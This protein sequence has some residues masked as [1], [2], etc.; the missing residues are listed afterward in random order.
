MKR[1]L[2]LIAVACW[3]LSSSVLFAD[4]FYKGQVVRVIV[5]G[6]VFNLSPPLSLTLRVC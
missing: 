1:R 5:G 4:D 3:F 6:S 2:G